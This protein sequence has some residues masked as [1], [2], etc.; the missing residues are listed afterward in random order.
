MSKKTL[1][2]DKTLKFDTSW[3]KPNK[4]TNRVK[5]YNVELL[6]HT[7]SGCDCTITFEYYNNPVEPSVT[8]TV[9]RTLTHNSSANNLQRI[10]VNEL[11]S[12]KRVRLIIS[13]SGTS[14]NYSIDR[15]HAEAVELNSPN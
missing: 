7:Q 2:T 13:D 6:V 9:T 5:L 14:R 4:P 15:I 1:S 12:G 8:R 3:I 10:F 11:I